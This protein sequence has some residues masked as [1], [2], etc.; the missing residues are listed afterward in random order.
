MDSSYDEVPRHPRVVAVINGK[1]G[2][3]KSSITANLGSILASMY[4]L[5]VLLVGLDP[6]DNL[7]EDLGYAHVEAGDDGQ[8]LVAAIQGQEVV[9]PPG[10]QQVRP[11]VDVLPG[12]DALEVLVADL[13]VDR[14]NGLERVWDLSSAL[15]NVRSAYDIVLI[16]CPPGYHVLQ[17][18]ALAAA[19]WML[20]PT[21]TDSSSRKGIA[22]LADRVGAVNEAGADPNLLGVVLFDLP[23]SATRVR[24]DAHERIMGDLG[25]DA[26]VFEVHIRSAAAAA[27]DARERGQ[28]MHE[29][30]RDVE[31]GPTWWQLRRQRSEEGEPAPPS[32]ALSRAAASVARD[33]E[34]LGME[35]MRALENAEALAAGGVSS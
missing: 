35:F 29:L 27:H 23:A 10:T 14:A 30:A 5:R 15:S 22:R 12:G 2:V 4:Q 1:G 28:L 6:Q 34:V 19:E 11:G 8:A 16:D 26:P 21:A 13:Y 18:L 20:V 33:Y 7:G 9:V 17:E 32:P 31:A 3:G 25:P 24:R